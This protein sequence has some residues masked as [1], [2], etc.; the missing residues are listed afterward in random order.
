MVATKIEVSRLAGFFKDRFGEDGDALPDDGY[1]VLSKRI[2]FDSSLMLGEHVSEPVLVQAESGMTFAGGAVTGTMFALNDPNAA[3]TQE[4]KWT[5]QEFVVRS[6]TSWKALR[7]A[8]TSEQAFG[9]AYDKQVRNMRRSGVFAREFSLLYGGSS[10]GRIESQTGSS[11]TR[12]WTLTKASSSAGAWWYLNGVLI[13]SYN[14]ES[15]GT[16]RNTNADIEVTGVDLSSAGKIL[17]SVSGNATDLT[18]ID[19]DIATGSFI[20]LKG[21]EGNMMQGIDFV[22]RNTGTYA[23]ISATTFPIWKSTSISASSAAATFAKFLQALKVNR[24][25]SGPGMRTAIIS[26]ATAQD[27]GDNMAALQRMVN[28]S[29]GKMELGADSIVYH[30]LG[31]HTIEFL[32]HVLCKEGEAFLVDFGELSRIGST[33]FTFDPTGKGEYFEHVSGF[34]GLE[35]MGYWDQGLRVASPASITKVTD[36]VNSF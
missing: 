18:T 27:L 2:A 9:S 33:D 17:V 6:R 35:L 22:A 36:I 4:A 3:L 19:G 28:K 34:A 23:N 21:A 24:L 10:L 30:A 16:K 5:S 32:P 11:G 7:A 20:L 1:D 31:G 25:K 29:G 15:G 26:E 14:A 13:D 12:V 8:Q